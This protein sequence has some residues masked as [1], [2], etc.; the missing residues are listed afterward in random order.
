MRVLDIPQQC[1]LTSYLEASPVPWYTYVNFVTFP[2]V[3][4]TAES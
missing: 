4:N 3:V 2:D 1:G